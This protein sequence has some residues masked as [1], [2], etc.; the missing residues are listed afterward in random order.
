MFSDRVPKLGSGDAG[1]IERLGPSVGHLDGGEEDAVAGGAQAPKDRLLD[2]QGVVAGG[3]VVF[4]EQGP[5]EAAVLGDAVVALKGA[6]AIFT[7]PCCAWV[8][9]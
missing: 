6:G 2:G 7:A 1:G 3:H 4:V 8:T 9:T 5:S